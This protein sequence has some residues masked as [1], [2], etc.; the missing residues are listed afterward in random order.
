MSVDRRESQ[1][2][3]RLVLAPQEGA[4]GGAAT[5]RATCRCGHTRLER[6]ELERRLR[7]GVGLRLRFC[8]MSPGVGSLLRNYA[9]EEGNVVRGLTEARG[10]VRIP[11]GVAVWYFSFIVVNHA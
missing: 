8:P 1:P 9:P 10:K 2:G 3:A 4:S 11:D 6:I 5:R 7:S